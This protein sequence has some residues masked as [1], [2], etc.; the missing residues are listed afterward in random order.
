[1]KQIIMFLLAGITLATAVS[2]KSGGPEDVVKKFFQAI[3]EKK[4]DEAKKYATKESQ[5]LLDMLATFSKSGAD[6]SQAKPKKEEQFDVTN[7]K[8]TGDNATADVVAKDKKSPLT[9]NLKKEE[10]KWK[11]AFDKSSIMK[12]AMDAQPGHM[13]MNHDAPSVTDSAFSTGT[14][15]SG[16]SVITVDSLKK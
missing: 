8:V 7:V 6:S 5:S 2:C 16:R 15:T 3:Q 9:I 14:D 12:M 11:V 4:F 1:M 10:G 13:N